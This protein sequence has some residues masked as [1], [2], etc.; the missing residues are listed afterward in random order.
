MSE[1][2]RSSSCS[3][4]YIFVFN[5]VPAGFPSG[6]A[7]S[8][9]KPRPWSV[10]RLGHFLPWRLRVERLG[11]HGGELGELRLDAQAHLHDLHE[12]GA[13]NHRADMLAPVIRALAGVGA[14]PLAP[15]D[16]AFGLE[17]LERATDGAA[18]DAKHL[19]KRPLGR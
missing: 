2:W 1:I 13:G 3:P 4:V 5:A 19:R 8:A 14:G 16:A 18:T 12:I 15:P 9:R 17:H 7:V 6:R 10:K 11:T